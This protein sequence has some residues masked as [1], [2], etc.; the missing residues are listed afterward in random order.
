[1]GEAIHRIPASFPASFL[2][3]AIPS[4]TAP[5]TIAKPS[6]H[7][8]ATLRRIRTLARITDGLI[9]IPG[10]G[11]K[12]GIDPIIGLITGG[13]DSLGFIMSTYILLESLRYKL[14]KETLVRMLSNVAIDAVVGTVPF[15]GDLFDFV[16]G[17]NTKNL[18]LLEAH[19]A[20]PIPQTAADRNFVLLILLGLAVILALALALAMFVAGAIGGLWSLL[21]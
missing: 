21:F 5:M 6:T 18:K 20:D 16:W 4:P 11:K 17:A 3:P 7:K 9:A 2:P 14:P 10:T 12:I 13:G 1:M 19:L 8:E 15:L